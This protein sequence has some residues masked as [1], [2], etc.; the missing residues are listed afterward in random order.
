[1]SGG[2]YHLLRKV[3][4]CETFGAQAID[5]IESGFC[6]TDTRG[7]FTQNHPSSVS[8]IVFTERTSHGQA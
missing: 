7:R 6:E 4:A 8:M 1:M 2:G 5:F 3:F